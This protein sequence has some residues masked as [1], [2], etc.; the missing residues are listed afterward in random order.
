MKNYIP[1]L[2]KPILRFLYYKNDRKKVIR[3]ISIRKEQNQLIKRFNTSKIENLILFIV[4][5]TNW[6][7][8]YDNISGGILSI[9]S[10][11]EETCK[12]NAIHGAEVIM[13][14]HPQAHLLLK[15]TQ[16]PN[17][18]PVFRFSQLH[19]FRHIKKLMVHIPEYLTSTVLGD[20]IQQTFKQLG[21]ENIHLNIMNQRIDIMPEPDVIH[22]LAHKGFKL[23]QTTA[24]Q[25][26][27]NQAIRD[28]FGIPL[29]KLSVYATPERYRYSTLETKEK[30]ILIS[31]DD[32]P[33]KH[34]ILDKLTIELPDYEIRIINGITYQAYL[35][36]VQK[37]SFTIT[38]GEGL[39]F[40]LI[41]TI[42]SGGVSF[43]V[44]NENFFTPDFKGLRGVY[45][46]DN[47]MLA[48]ITNDIKQLENNPENY[49]KTNQQQFEPCHK[50]YN[51]KDY[52]DN[53]ISFYKGEYLFP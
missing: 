44:Y 20:N 1:N 49:L 48:T 45:N 24:H 31:P 22:S 28:K 23:T 53:L 30:L 38:F 16:F 37:A 5:G 19:H 39:D 51:H 25:Q 29:H 14:T 43:S 40:Y 4:D 7:T 46:S 10:I 15:H 52:Q 6:F 9:A 34:A 13:V 33:L 35:N 36:L 11:Y 8:G 32:A 42:F 17:N 26:Y 50:I 47:E 3:E 21:A 12:L 2:I 27:S 18:I 41:E